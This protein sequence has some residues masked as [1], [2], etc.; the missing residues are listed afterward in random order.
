MSVNAHLL[1]V[2]ANILEEVGDVLAQVGGHILATLLGV[3]CQALD[4]IDSLTGVGESCKWVVLADVLWVAALGL[5]TSG[6]TAGVTSALQDHV[7]QA[8]TCARQKEHMQPDIRPAPPIARQH[9][10]SGS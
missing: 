5:Q 4:G 8:S 7:S 3:A 1:S 2:L 6:V 9:R 10:P